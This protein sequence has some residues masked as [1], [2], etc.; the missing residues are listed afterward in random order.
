MVGSVCWSHA[1]AQGVKP[2][3]GDLL[4]AGPCASCMKEKAGPGRTR[5]PR[6][7]VTMHGVKQETSACLLSFSFAQGRSNEQAWDAS[8]ELKGGMAY[9]PA[10]AGP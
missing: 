2:T 4:Y 9:W 5:V 6:A 7:S 10:S 8:R 3:G 1:R